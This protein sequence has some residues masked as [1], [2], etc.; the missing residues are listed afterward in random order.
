MKSIDSSLVE[1]R[2]NDEAGYKPLVYYEGWRVAILNDAEKFR[3][4][5]ITFMERHD[6]TDEVFVLLTGTA[7]LY[8]GDG[9]DDSPGQITLLPMEPEKIYNVKKG[10]WHCHVSTPGTAILIVENADTAKTNS[11][12][13]PVTPDRLPAQE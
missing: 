6:L 2:Q 3:R 8:I 10:V 7:S 13:I 4:E 1:I 12:Y 5:Q 11:H 9:G